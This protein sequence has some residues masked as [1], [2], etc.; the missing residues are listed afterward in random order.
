MISEYTITNF[1]AFSKPAT[2]PIKP[3]TLIFGPNSSG[4]SSIF[5][6]MLMLK[7]SIEE[8]RNK[9]DPLLPNGGLISLG[10][11]REFIHN[12]DIKK[13][14]SIQVMLVEPETLYYD[15]LSQIEGIGGFLQ[16][17]LY[18]FEKKL[19]DRAVG[20]RIN[21]KNDLM[22]NDLLVSSIEL[23]IDN[24]LSPILTYRIFPLPEVKTIDEWYDINKNKQDIKF[25]KTTLYL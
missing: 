6:S 15:K 19:N 5:H 7:Q 1:K 23:F 12:H 17:V 22:M 8:A 24:V 10:N 9:D 13:E 4:K 18:S 14:F 20:V 11:Y 3:I 25:N 2:I 16:D 21:F